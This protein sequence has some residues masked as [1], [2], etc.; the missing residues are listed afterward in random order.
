MID[1]AE[2]NIVC[3]LQIF[4]NEGPQT[5]WS[6]MKKEVEAYPVLWLR[7]RGQRSETGPIRPPTAMVWQLKTTGARGAAT[8]VEM[9]WSPQFG[10]AIVKRTL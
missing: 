9:Q 4:D 1:E 5:G 10:K 8:L 7:M 2:R 3:M 6:L